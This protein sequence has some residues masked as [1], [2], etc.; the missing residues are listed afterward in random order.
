[1]CLHLP[2]IHAAWIGGATDVSE[3]K[4]RKKKKG[5][6]ASSIRIVDEDNTGFRTGPVNHITEEDDEDEGEQPCFQQWP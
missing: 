5:V 4:K 2:D 6:V 1:M 3:K